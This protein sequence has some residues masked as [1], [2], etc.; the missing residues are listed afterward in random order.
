MAWW[1]WVLIAIAVVVVIAVVVWRALA[2]YRPRVVVIEYN[3]G[4]GPSMDWKVRYDP[5]QTWMVG[6]SPKSDIN[7]ALATFVFGNERLRP[8]K[9]FG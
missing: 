9:L 1:V 7:P 5:E 4:F 8:A 6:N 3:A 2:R